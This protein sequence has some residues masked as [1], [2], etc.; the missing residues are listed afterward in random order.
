MESDAREVLAGD[1]C[2]DDR[3]AAGPL[4]RVAQGGGPLVLDQQDGCNRPG[5]DCGRRVPEFGRVHA[6]EVREVRSAAI[7]QRHQVAPRPPLGRVVLELRHVQVALLVLV[8]EQ[9]I[10][11]ADAGRSAQAVELGADLVTEI[12][13]GERDREQLNRPRAHASSLVLAAANS[14]VVSAPESSSSFSLVKSETRSFREAT[15][16]AERTGIAT[17]GSAARPPGT[18]GR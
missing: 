11:Q 13:A 6:L 5:R 18:G 2:V 14:S 7:E 17:G 10:E 12:V 1:P 15:T 4:K 3:R 9:R 8:D 16:A